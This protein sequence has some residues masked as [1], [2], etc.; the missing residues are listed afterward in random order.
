[1]RP[2]RRDPFME[3]ASGKKDAEA[4]KVRVARGEK[5]R[6]APAR[7][8]AAASSPAASAARSLSRIDCRDTSGSPREG[9][10]PLSP[11]SATPSPS[12]ADPAE[13]PNVARANPGGRAA[14]ASEGL[15]GVRAA[16]GQE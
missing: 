13:A 10:H 7:T 11:R 4:A 9:A 16:V 2:S 15:G 1:M 6:D 3:N 8:T 14:P 5:M 12:S